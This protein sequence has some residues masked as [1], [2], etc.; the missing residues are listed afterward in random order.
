MARRTQILDNFVAHLATNTD[1]LEENITKRF[2]YLHEV[3][4]FPAVCMMPQ[5]ELRIHRGAD[6]R[7]GIINLFLRAYVY[8][9]DDVMGA[10]DT[11]GASLETAAQSYAATQRSI[12]LE[13]ARVTSFR[14]DEGLF[15]PYGIVDMEIQFLYEVSNEIK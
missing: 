1:V 12:Q 14:T 4:D 5:S 8:D 9:G 13:E 2:A 11:L 6:A 15:Q 7:Q 3:N 10:C